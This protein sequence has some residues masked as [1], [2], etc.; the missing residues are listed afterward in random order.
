MDDDNIVI[1]I[2]GGCYLSFLSKNYRS[3]L[4]GLRCEYRERFLDLDRERL[5]SGLDE[6]AFVL[7]RLSLAGISPK[8]ESKKS[9]APDGGVDFV[10]DMN[11][12]LLICQLKWWTKRLNNKVV[13]NI[14]GDIYFSEHGMRARE[15]NLPIK[16][17]LIAPIIGKVPQERYLRH[18]YILISGERFVKFM[19]N[20]YYFLKYNLEAF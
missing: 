15:Q 11:S 4:L 14:Y 6:E 10:L 5:L 3:N 17:L 12:T 16:Y 1:P 2:I 13:K 20:P 8:Y 18:G 9:N 19:S 7:R